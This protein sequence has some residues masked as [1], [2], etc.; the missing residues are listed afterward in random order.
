MLTIQLLNLQFYAYHGV[1]EEEQKIGAEYEVNMSVMHVEKKVPVLHLSETI[2]YVSVYELIKKH[3]QT[4][5]QLLETVAT[6]LAQDIFKSFA[7]AEELS[8]TI[9][10]K[11]PPIAAFQGSVAVTY[12]SKRSD[13]I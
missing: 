11:H 12:T 4:P 5:R 7:E 8:I 6:I 10:K 2:N 1:Y 3:M 13:N 9:V